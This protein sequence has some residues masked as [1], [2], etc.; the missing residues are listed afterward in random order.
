MDGWTDEGWMKIWMDRSWMD[1]WMMGDWVMRMDR[2]TNELMD[3]WIM[4]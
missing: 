3:G 4:D 1:G 2:W